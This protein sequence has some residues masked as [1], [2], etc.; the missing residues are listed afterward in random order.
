MYHLQIPEQY[1]RKMEI[2]TRKWH[3]DRFVDQKQR[4]NEAIEKER[5]KA[6]H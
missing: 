1:V 3:I 6:R 2:F 4:E 5:K